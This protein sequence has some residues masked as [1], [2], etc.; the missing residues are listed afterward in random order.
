[1]NSGD[2]IICYLEL[3]KTQSVFPIPLEFEILKFAC[4]CMLFTCFSY[5]LCIIPCD[6]GAVKSSAYQYGV[7]IFVGLGLHIHQTF[8]DNFCLEKNTHKRQ[9]QK[10][11]NHPFYHSIKVN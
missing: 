2:V 8:S 1:M 4:I 11:N 6:Y 3:R 7:Q 9:Q 5:V 10:N